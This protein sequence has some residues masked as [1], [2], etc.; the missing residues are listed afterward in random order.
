MRVGFAARGTAAL[1]ARRV[2]KFRSGGERRS[3]FAGQLGIFGQHDRKVLVRHRHDSIFGAVDHRDGSAPVTLAGDAPV[4]EAKNR[5][6]LAKVFGLR[7][8]CHRKD[9]IVDRQAAVRAG[10]HYLAALMFVEC[11]GHFFGIER[12]GVDGLHD[13]ANG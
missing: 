8:R 9:G 2:H 4:F 10:V 5:L 13:H 12:L 6:A 7:V 3:A 11:R 1:R